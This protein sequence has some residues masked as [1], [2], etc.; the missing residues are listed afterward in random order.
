[1]QSFAIGGGGGWEAMHAAGVPVSAANRQW[2]QFGCSPP[3]MPSACGPAILELR[4]M[5]RSWDC[6]QL[7]FTTWWPLHA[8]DSMRLAS[9]AVG[10]SGG[11]GEP[12]IL[13]GSL[14]TKSDSP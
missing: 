5:L 2:R 1:M 6:F 7:A 10:N 4:R 3:N 11:K 8:W 14:S 9:K 12:P 13:R